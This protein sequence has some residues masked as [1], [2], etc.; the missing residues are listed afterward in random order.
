[1]VPLSWPTPAVPIKKYFCRWTAVGKVENCAVDLQEQLLA[2]MI[3]TNEWSFLTLSPC[4]LWA[5]IKGRT[6]WFAGDSMTKD[7]FKAVECFMY[8]FWDSESWEAMRRQHREPHRDDALPGDASS[9]RPSCIDLPEGN[10]HISYSMQIELTSVFK[11]R[12]G[13]LNTTDA[14]CKLQLLDC[15]LSV[16]QT[17]MRYCQM[18]SLG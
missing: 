16:D 11:P 15:A 8:E 17:Q 2:K 9:M 14:I 12:S 7:L 5:M 4:D 6:T 1:M 13:V 10:Q 18:L 3:A